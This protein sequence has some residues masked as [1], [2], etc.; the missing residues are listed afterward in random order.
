MC[1]KLIF[2]DDLEQARQTG[3]S[4]N[5]NELLATVC[6]VFNPALS[7]KSKRFLH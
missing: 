6:L 3:A 7:A 1:E 4:V 2:E 5:S